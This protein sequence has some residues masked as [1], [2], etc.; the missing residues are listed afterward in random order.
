MST[1]FLVLVTGMT[2][3]TGPE[4]ISEETEQ[5]LCL[6]GTWTGTQQTGLVTEQVTFQNGFLVRDKGKGQYL[7][8][9]YGNGQCCL[10]YDPEEPGCGNGIA[11]RITVSEGIYQQTSGH[12]R[13][14]LSGPVRI[15]CGELRKQRPT[16]FVADPTHRL[17]I[18][19][20]VPVRKK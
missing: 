9:D 4:R 5:R 19:Q 2:V 1:L 18:I 8:V 3:G 16:G 10:L 11:E 20:R 6:D 7:L 17:F 13:I 15:F 14:C 12:L